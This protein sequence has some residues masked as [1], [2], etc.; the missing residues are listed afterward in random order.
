MIVDVF[1]SILNDFSKVRYG[2]GIQNLNSNIVCQFLKVFELHFIF[3]DL[4]IENEINQSIKSRKPNYVY[5][6]G[7]LIEML[8]VYKLFFSRCFECEIFILDSRE[9]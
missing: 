6:V 1:I 8:N 7:N 4:F 9:I 2:V 3:F 5:E